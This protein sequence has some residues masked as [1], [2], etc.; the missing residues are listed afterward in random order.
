[1]EER[2]RRA[3]TWTLEPGCCRSG[4]SPQFLHFLLGDAIV[5]VRCRQQPLERLLAME[6][7]SL[8]LFL[9]LLREASGAYLKLALFLRNPKIL[10]FIYH[11]FH[12]H[13]E[14][15]RFEGR[16][17]DFEMTKREIPLAFISLTWAIESLT[18]NLGSYLRHLFSYLFC[19]QILRIAT[20]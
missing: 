2:W 13:K 11:P 3:W 19:Y 9:S 6:L 18:N 10:Q 5:K 7:H 17:G 15:Q 16:V 12:R 4:Q 1:M 20:K 8:S 14:T